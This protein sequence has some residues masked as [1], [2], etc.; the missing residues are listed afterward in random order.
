MDALR[1]QCEGGFKM[2]AYKDKAQGTWYVSFRYIDWTGKK[3]QKLKRGFKTKREALNYENEFK[4]SVAVEP[5]MQM[6]KFVDIYFSDKKNELKAN[7]IR[8]KQHMI[9]K[10]IIPYFGD[11]KLNEITPA[12]IIQW[13]KI[14]QKNKFSKTYERMIQNQI[15]ALFNHAQRIYNLKE[16]P[17]KKVK[18]MGKS[19]ADKLDFWIKEEYDRF[20]SGV[21]RKS[22]DYL[23]FE[24]LFWTGIREGELLSLTIADF[25]MTNNLLHIN[26][27][28]HRIDGKDV[29]STPK[30]DNSVR[31]I[32]IPNFL[33]E[34]VQEYISYHYGFPEN[35]RLFP[36]VARTL[37]KRM[38]RYEKK[39]GVKPIRVHDLRHSHVAYLINQGVEP[40]IIKERLGHKN[41]QI[42]LNTYGHLY[43]SRQ[44]EV[45]A[46]LD[47]KNKGRADQQ[48]IMKMNDVGKKEKAQ[49]KNPGRF[50]GNQLSR[51]T[52]LAN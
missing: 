15:N 46:L 10:H 39:T 5:D 11:K 1:E 14:I 45:A 9:N 17:C 26:K 41:I 50:F 8:N 35:E 33:K 25:D 7:S 20:I 34:E 42:T 16:N 51:Y 27:T 19:D 36:I 24:I 21:D 6:A 48:E 13:Q 28:Y 4:N 31:T 18:R 37:Q 22:E 49:I 2:S 47:E 44:K 3:T 38:K 52:N 29:I 43:P 32:I 12:D 23:M 40:L 30:T